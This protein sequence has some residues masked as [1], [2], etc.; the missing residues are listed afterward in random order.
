[1]HRYELER[2]FSQENQQKQIQKCSNAST[3]VN[4][5]GYDLVYVSKDDMI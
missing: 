5:N 4:V 1:M 2:E 3:E